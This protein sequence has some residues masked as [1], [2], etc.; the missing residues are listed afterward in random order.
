MSFQ[1]HITREWCEWAVGIG[2]YRII[3]NVYKGRRDRYGFNSWNS[4]INGVLAE[5]VFATGYGLD[6]DRIRTSR[7]AEPDFVVE[8]DHWLGLPAGAWD[9]KHVGVDRN[10]QPWPLSV[11][12]ELLER[13]PDWAFCKVTGTVPDFTVHGYATGRHIINAGQ[14]NTLFS[15]PVINIDDGQLQPLDQP[16]PEPTIDF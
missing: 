1:V 9:V 13:H 11:K 2:T 14:R 6:R 8:P 7:I 16:Q 5:L 12:T 4:H 3:D 15:Q 10:G